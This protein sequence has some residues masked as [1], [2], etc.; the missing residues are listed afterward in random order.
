MRVNE[1]FVSSIA[2]DSEPDIHV[3][4]TC[5]SEICL[6]FFLSKK[7]LAMVMCASG[8]ARNVVTSSLYFIRSKG[9]SFA[10]VGIKMI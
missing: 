8:G 9:L 2:V 4:T 1:A 10:N 6:F 3:P 7:M 5:I